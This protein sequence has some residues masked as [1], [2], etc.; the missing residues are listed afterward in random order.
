[1]N[2]EALGEFFLNLSSFHTAGVPFAKTLVLYGLGFSIGKN[3]VKVMRNRIR[4]S[5]ATADV[6]RDTIIAFL[7]GYVI[8][9]AG[10][11]IFISNSLDTAG[12]IISQT[13]G[14]NSAV[15]V[16][17]PVNVFFGLFYAMGADFGSVSILSLTF[18]AVVTGALI[19]AIFGFLFN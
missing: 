12:R 19:R 17:D 18:P 14:N 11:G 9:A 7:I 5:V 13:L 4:I 16:S 2:T 8:G 10:V 6:I 3:I 1:M 15:F